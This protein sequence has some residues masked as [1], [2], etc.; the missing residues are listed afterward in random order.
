MDEE[1]ILNF[2][3]SKRNLSQ[4]SRR[5]YTNSIRQYSTYTGKTI[6]ELHLE[7][8]RD[9]EDHTQYY[10]RGYV[11]DSLGFIEHLKET[12]S[13][14]TV[15]N[16]I[17]SITGFYKAYRIT[18]P[19][20]TRMRGDIALERN[21]G[22][23]LTRGEIQ[24]LVAVAS[25]RNRALIYLMSLSGFSQQEVANLTVVKFLDA[26]NHELPRPC[27]AIED[28]FHT[29][30]EDVTITLEI[31]RRKVHYRYM[32]CIPPETIR[33][34]V[35]Y[36]EERVHH[37]GHTLSDPGA[38]L[39][40]RENGEKLT[41]ASV[42]CTFQRLGDRAG[43]HHQHGVYRY[44]RS[45]GLRRYFIS[46]IISRTGDSV[47]ADF[48]A[49]HKISDQ[50]RTYWR[51]NPENLKERYLKVLPY[52]SLDGLEVDTLTTQDKKRLLELEVRGRDQELEI[53]ALREILEREV[54]V[55]R[56]DK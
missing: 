9:E 48:L 2:W 11:H 49:G 44:W 5:I 8:L 53:R 3:F 12:R 34:V 45:H 28:L 24:K 32:T 20:L 51:A 21:F 30:L 40:S 25:P 4:N 54:L 18:P 56:H 35:N 27:H 46:T 42:T 52:L 14:S 33:Q 7:A 6:K 16:A 43:F 41:G 13:M 50:Q 23:L 10:Q 55:D 26:V 22:Q 39:I 1:K 29:D 36:L 19:E 38:S 17:N 37:Y 15:N 47:L 31:I